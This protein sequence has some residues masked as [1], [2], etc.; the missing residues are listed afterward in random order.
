MYYAY[1]NVKVLSLVT[2]IVI[3]AVVLIIV[4]F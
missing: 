4:V 1:V 2:F 3:V